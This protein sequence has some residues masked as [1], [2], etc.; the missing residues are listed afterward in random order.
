MAHLTLGGVAHLRLPGETEDFCRMKL[1][2][3]NDNQITLEIEDLREKNLLT[4]PLG[5]DQPAELLVNGKG[6]R[7]LYPSVQVAAKD[8][9]TSNIAF[10]TLTEATAKK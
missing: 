9:D 6:Y 3:G 10:V 2:K 5:R 4:V 8:P 7:V 1:V